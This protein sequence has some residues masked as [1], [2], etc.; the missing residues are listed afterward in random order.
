MVGNLHW[1]RLILSPLV[2]ALAGR[3]LGKLFPGAGTSSVL[4]DSSQIMAVKQNWKIVSIVRLFMLR[5][6]GGTKKS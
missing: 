4:I 5:L 6:S 1:K 2:P 3:A